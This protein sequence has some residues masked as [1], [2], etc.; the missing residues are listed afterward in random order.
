MIVVNESNVHDNLSSFDKN[1]LATKIKADESLPNNSC[2]THTDVNYSYSSLYSALASLASNVLINITTDVKLLSIVTL[3]DLANVTIIGHNN[4]TINCDN[5]GG[6]HFMNCSHCIIDGITWVGCGAGNNVGNNDPVLKFFNSSNIVI[7]NCSFQHSIG[8]AVV[9]SGVSGN[10]S[11]AY[12]NFASNEQYEGHGIAIHYSSINT[13]LNPSLSFT[14]TNCKFLYNKNAKSVVYFGQSSTKVYAY[15]KNCNFFHNTAVPVYLTYQNLYISGNNIIYK[16]TAE[17]GGGIFISNYSNVTFHKSATVNFTSNMAKNNGGAIFITDHSSIIFKDHLIDNQPY[18]DWNNQLKYFEPVTGTL[19]INSCSTAT[20]EG[21]F[22]V[23]FNSNS[24]KHGGALY[25]EDSDVTFKG[26]STVRLNNNNADYG[27]AVYIKDSNVIFEGNST[28]T[29]NKNNADNNGGAVFIKNSNI[30]F[31]GNLTLTFDNNSAKMNGGAIDI[32]YYSNI[33]FKGKLTVTFNNSNAENNGGALNIHHYSNVTFEGSSTA[34]F[35][36]NNADMAGGAVYIEYYCNVTFEGN[37]TVTLNKN[38]AENNGGALNIHHYSNVT[39]EGNSTAI[40]NNNTADM[41]GGAVYIAYYCNVTFKGNSTVRLNNNN[42]DY[43]GAVYIK[44]SNVTFEGNSTV[45]LNN[46]NADIDG[47]GLDIFNYSDV[48]FRG[49]SAVTFNNNNAKH[50][51]AMHIRQYCDVTFEGNSRVT[52]NNNNAD[53]NGGAVFINDSN[54]TFE[55]NSTL[56]FNNN[57]AK[58]NGGAIDIYYYSNVTFKGKLTLT[59][60]NNNAENNGGALS[61]HHYSNIMFEGNSAATFN[62]NNADIHGGAVHIEFYCNV[63]FEGN[64]IITFNNN[65]VHK[66]GGAL[67]VKKRCNITFEGNSIALTFDNNNSDMLA[68]ALHIDYYSSII[69]EGNL[70]VTFNNNNG[71]VRGGAIAVYH[72]SNVTVAGNSIVTFNN[73]SAINLGGALVIYDISNV[74][75]VKGNSI[76]TFNN[77]R[78]K[79]GGAIYI[80]VHCNVTFQENS[81][82]TFNNNIGGDFGGAVFNYGTF[83]CEEN[84]KVNFN[85]NCDMKYDGGALYTYGLDTVEFKGNSTV[86]FNNNTANNNGGA[87]AINRY[88]AIIFEE[89][90]IVSFIYNTAKFNGAAMYI[91]EYASITFEGNSTVTFSNNRAY[92]DG[93]AVFIHDNSIAAINGNSLVSFELSTAD[94]NGGAIFIDH[95]S[96]IRCKDN[97]TVTFKNNMATN[98]GAMYVDHSTIQFKGNNIMTFYNN[99]SN[100][101]NITFTKSSQINTDRISSVKFTSNKALQ[102]GGAICLTDNSN[103]MHSEGLIVS[104]DNNAAVDYGG[105]IYA[106]FE[107]STINLNSSDIYFQD[108]TAGKI[109]KTIFIYVPKSCNSSCLF[110]NVNIINTK[111]ISLAT[112]PS[113][114]ILRSPTKCINGSDTDCVTYY[115]N[116]IMLGQEI[117]FEA[118]VLDYYDQPTEAVEFSVTGMN[119]EDYHISGSQHISVS[120]NYTIQGISINGSLHS[121]SSYNYSVFISTYFVRI[122][123][124]KLISVNLVV[125]ISQCHLGFWHSSRSQICECFNTK[126][127]ISCSGSNSTIKKNYWFG[128][129]SGKSTVASCPNNYC[130]FTCCQ[131]TSGIYHL[132]PIRANQCKPHRSGIAC[133]NCQ[134]GYTLSFDSPECVEVNKCTVGHTVLVIALSMLYWI[135]IVVAVFVMMHFKVTVGSLYAIIYYYSIVDILLGRILFVS[136]GLYTTVNILSSLAKLTP[137]FLGQLCLVR[138]MSGIDQYFI[139]YVHPAVVLFTLIM[140]SVLARRSRRVSSFVSRGVIHFI[141]FLLLLS[142]TSVVTTS[143]LLMRPLKFTDIEEIYT[144]LSPDIEYCHGRHLVYMIVAIISTIAFAFGLPLLLLLEPFLNSK[145]NFIKLKPL[146][147]QFQCCYKDKYRCFAG[148]YM[149]C[150]LVII[151]LVIINILNEFTTQYLLISSCAIM[152]LIH[153][154]VRPYASTFLNVFD[155]ITLQLIVII[156]ALPLV[157]Y[158]GNYNETLVLLITYLLVMWPLASYI[159]IKLWIYRSNIQN[160]IKYLIKK[161]SNEYQYS[162]VP[163]DDDNEPNEMNEFNIVVDDNTRR[164]VPTFL[165]DM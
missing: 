127:I 94:G 139:H 36:N 157:E 14:I 71:N 10:I 145:I 120:C 147:D 133:G 5:S 63:T 12:C 24:A 155:G 126:N 80:G 2:C 33:T 78:A 30:T 150:R 129:V 112:S 82:V 110:H 35:N 105:A 7:D 107:N 83:I 144:Y 39:F 20:Y 158:V 132:S 32:Y 104:F 28:V 95:H 84:S 16:N 1:V 56:T 62:H 90:T 54:V 44:D 50:G 53:I 17:N 67:S 34:I 52:C 103:F 58:M 119:H 37:S 121:N 124:S 77:N 22:T 140:I 146:L 11:I 18:D 73:N 97:P 48:T 59:F 65:N 75:I 130:D 8:Q 88:S 134:K 125:E 159:A 109:H 149:I 81:T 55:G 49:N 165:V 135:G 118:C 85:N 143:L 68:G 154:L 91:S 102:D 76:V 123:R 101:S 42:A 141:C 98:G 51:G 142:Y 13:P 64:S 115:M 92:G 161:C 25:I 138:N 41:H 61:I 163:T 108:N 57:S 27:G 9:I 46:N 122:S 38:N 26:N 136:N 156:S 100:Y 96:L 79:N 15:L 128:I 60:N 106:L 19:C 70:T 111:N 151:L 137:Q 69:F 99:S 117:I 160:A 47:G 40:F 131:I 29:L 89:N 43:G 113:K 162:P 148:Y 152:E 93:G 45:A 72:S 23:T 116:N 31:E 153:L 86:T 114:L 4:P 6:V 66:Y 87:V 164:N 3:Y 21:N 74:I